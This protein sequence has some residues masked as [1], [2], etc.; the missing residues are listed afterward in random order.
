MKVYVTETFN[1][2][3]FWCSITPQSSCLITYLFSAFITYTPGFKWIN[4]FRCYEAKIEESE[5]GRQPPGVESGGKILSA[6]SWFILGGPGNEATHDL[7]IML[8][9]C[10][11]A[12]KHTYTNTHYL[13]THYSPSIER[14]SHTHTHTKDGCKELPY[15]ICPPRP[16]KAG[17]PVRYFREHW[18]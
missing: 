2:I 1:R 12:Y 15:G 18:A 9:T 13:Y 6:Y 11:H 16:N 17:T 14:C 10:V 4:E 8:V 3:K 7:T 5:K